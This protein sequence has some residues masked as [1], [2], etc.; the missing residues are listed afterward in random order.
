[1]RTLVVHPCA[2]S[3]FGL[4]LLFP[5]TSDKTET[6][7]DCGFV[8]SCDTG[9]SKRRPSSTHNVPSNP[10]RAPPRPSPRSM[11]S[12]GADATPVSISESFDLLSAV[13][14]VRLV[15]TA[16]LTSDVQVSTL[17]YFSRN[18]SRVVCLSSLL[19]LT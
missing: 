11:E 3:G 1:M 5:P 19:R 6:L 14:D 13:A 2:L 18:F 9:V 17:P 7:P 12:G 8:F 15:L 16:R 10:C 4:L